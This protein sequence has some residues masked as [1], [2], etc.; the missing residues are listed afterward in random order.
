MISKEERRFTVHIHLK[1]ADDSIMITGPTRNIGWQ[2]DNTDSPS[3]NVDIRTPKSIKIYTN[4][5]P[6]YT[7]M[8]I[9]F[10]NYENCL[11]FAK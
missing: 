9:V 3:P 2:L 4:Q 10:E 5:S 6:V 11:T 1:L 8:F 7:F